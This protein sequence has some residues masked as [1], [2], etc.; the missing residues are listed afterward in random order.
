MTKA[1][2]NDRVKSLHHLEIKGIIEAN[3]GIV[4]FDSTPN[5]PSGFF[6]KYIIKLP[7]YNE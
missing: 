1:F 4:D 2:N 5:N 7:I 6:V 3:G